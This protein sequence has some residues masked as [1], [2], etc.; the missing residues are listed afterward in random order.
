MSDFE[1]ATTPPPAPTGAAPQEERTMAMLAHLLGIITWFIGPLIIWLMNKDKNPNSFVSD[2]AKE[3]LNFQITLGIV[4][5]IGIILSV[6]VIGIFI[7]MLAGLA[8]LIFAIIGGIKANGGEAYRYP[9]AL[10]LIK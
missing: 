10:R 2:Q 4:Y 3:A 5:L 8:G 9:F 1:N 7:N 6:I